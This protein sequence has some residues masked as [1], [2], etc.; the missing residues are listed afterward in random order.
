MRILCIFEIFRGITYVNSSILYSNNISMI[1]FQ[2][3]KKIK[4]ILHSPVFIIILFVFLIILI[5]AIFSVYQKQNMSAINLNKERMEYEKMNQR[6]EKL[7][8]SIE[9][10]KTDDGVESE[11]RTKF[12][13]IKQGE[14][15]AVIVNDD[16]T[17]TSTAKIDKNTKNNSITASSTSFFARIFNT[18]FK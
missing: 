1:D 16:S 8:S 4:N 6:K 10:L 7:V 3:K 15:I 13:L 18:L 12:R 5:R 9:Y 11:I 17:T 14:S 2:K